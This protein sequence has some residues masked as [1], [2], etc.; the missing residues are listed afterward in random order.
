MGLPDDARKAL[1]AAG[2][3]VRPPWARATTEQRREFYTLLR[4]RLA[5]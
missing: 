4:V 2:K 3:I 1:E 5:A